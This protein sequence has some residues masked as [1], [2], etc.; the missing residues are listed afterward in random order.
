MQFYIIKMENMKG[1]GNNGNTILS[2]QKG[3]E[4]QSKKKRE[5][6]TAKGV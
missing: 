6:K 5:G 4:S 2:G 1:Q 3:W